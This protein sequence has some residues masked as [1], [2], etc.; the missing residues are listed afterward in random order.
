MQQEARVGNQEAFYMNEII[1][2]EIHTGLKIHELLK[3]LEI[4]F[5][6]GDMN[7]AK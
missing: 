3:E 4:T 7:M 5:S 2:V 6:I 1:C